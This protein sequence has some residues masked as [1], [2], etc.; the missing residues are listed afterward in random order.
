MVAVLPEAVMVKTGG[1]P[2]AKGPPVAGPA[3]GVVAVAPPLLSP[4]MTLATTS[5][6]R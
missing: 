3:A 2:V 1:F 6:T 5:G 4:P